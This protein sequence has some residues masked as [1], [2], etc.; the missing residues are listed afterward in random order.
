MFAAL[1]I[2]ACQKS[3]PSGLLE[4]AA[5]LSAKIEQSVQSKTEL[6]ENNNILWSEND[7]IVGY[8]RSSYGYKYQ[9]KPAIGYPTLT[10]GTTRQ[11]G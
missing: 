1:S 8:I 3:V 9:V 7:Q 5:I 11:H 4:D 10:I 6:D 2:A